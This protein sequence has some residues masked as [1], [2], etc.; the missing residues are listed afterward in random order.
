MKGQKKQIT[1][2]GIVT[3]WEWDSDDLVAAMVISTA[4][5]EDFVVREP[6][7]VN[8]LRKHIDDLVQVTGEAGMDDAGHRAIIPATVRV[9]ESGWDDPSDVDGDEV[10][11]KGDEDDDETD[12]DWDDHD[13]DWD[14][15][16]R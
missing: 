8:R 9:I 10:G 12:D 3:P 13:D 14:E 15:D 16:E 2:R 4:Q 7:M 5:E 6:S 11:D 1:I